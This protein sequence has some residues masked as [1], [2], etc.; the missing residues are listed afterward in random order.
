MRLAA[1]N[2]QIVPGGHWL[3]IARLVP[4]FGVAQALQAITGLLVA[5]ILFPHE[6]GL[7]S[8]FAVVLFYSAQ[9]H[10]GSINLMHKEVP[11]FLAA[12][13]GRAAERVTNFAFSLSLTNCTV[14][15]AAI[16]AVGWLWRPAGVS[17]TQVTL[18]ALLVVSQELFTFVNY[19]LRA[20]GRFSALG[21]YLNLY[22]CSTLALVAPLGWWKHLTGVLLAY[23]LAGSSVSF[24]FIFRQRIR[25]AYRLAAHDGSLPRAFQLLLWTMMFVFLTT[26]DR[27]FIGGRLGVMALGFFGIALLVSNVVYNTSDVVLQVLFP[28][29]NSLAG[30]GQSSPEITRLL[31]NSARTLSYILAAILGLGFLLLPALVPVI[32][33]RYSPGI[34]AARIVCLGLAP[35]VLAQLISVGLVVMGRVMQCL[36]L[37]AAV[38]MFKL[39]LLLALSHPQ[40]TDVA[41]VS[42]LANVLYLLAV[43]TATA[44]LSAWDRLKRL[45][46]LAAPWLLVAVILLIVSLPTSLSASY[47]LGVLLPSSLYLVFAPPL[48]WTVYRRTRGALHV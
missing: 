7:W 2:P 34:P 31:L 48:L 17:F 46:S 30:S 39:I 36:L 28:T 40:L 21:D 5:R 3:Q 43:L 22:A 25:V 6:Y 20:Q 16:C 32:L 37:Q 14:V 8:L 12:K 47:G 9:L 13:D 11:F 19:W 27:V 24:Y 23:V 35:L 41:A 45:V 1:E 18:L 15:A 44:P 38:L 42:S 10:L 29:A 33:P 4:S 26:V